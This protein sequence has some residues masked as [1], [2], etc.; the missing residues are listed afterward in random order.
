MNIVQ[1]FATRYSAWAHSALVAWNTFVGFYVGSEQVKQ[2]VQHLQATLHLPTWMLAL[3]TSL[4]NITF[5]YRNWKK[6]H[7]AG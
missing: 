6:A 7:Q 1:Y 2:E 3:V 4:A 5:M